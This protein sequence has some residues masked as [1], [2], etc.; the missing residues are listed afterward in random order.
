VL[1]VTYYHLAGTYTY[2]HDLDHA[3]ADFDQAL[4]LAETYTGAVAPL[5]APGFASERC[6]K[7]CRSRSYVYDYHIFCARPDC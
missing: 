7:R 3:I 1:A 6:N 4:K 5:L 2:K